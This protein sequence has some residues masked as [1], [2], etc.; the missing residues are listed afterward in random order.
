MSASVSSPESESEGFERLLR[1]AQVGLSDRAEAWPA[2]LGVA[3]LRQTEPADYFHDLL[4][5]ATSRSDL[6]FETRQ[7]WL[8]LSR[9][10]H[11]TDS[12][13]DRTDLAS[14]LLAYAHRCPAYGWH[15]C[16]VLLAARLLFVGCDRE[17][18]FWCLVAIVEQ[19]PGATRL[20]GPHRAAD[21]AQHDDLVRARARARVPNPNPNPNPGP[22]LDPGGGSGDDGAAPSRLAQGGLG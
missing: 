1:L 14:V 6:A 21:L 15:P 17:T 5:L 19:L 22:D 2:L 20:V 7:I 8:D 3:A 12:A 13:A 9:T 4:E 18:A 11:P 16:R 10:G